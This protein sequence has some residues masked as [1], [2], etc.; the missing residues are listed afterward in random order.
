MGR[1]RPAEVAM[2]ARPA[3]RLARDHQARPRHGALL[4][5]SPRVNGKARPRRGLEAGAP[6]RIL[7][8]DDPAAEDST[9]AP[10]LRSGAA[11]RAGMSGG[12]TLVWGAGAIGG[13]VGAFLKRAGEDV[14][15]VDLVPEHVEAIRGPGGLR[16]TGPVEEFAV[17]APAL[18][19]EEAEGVCRTTPRRPAAPS[20]RTWTRT[21][22]CSRSRTACA[23]RPS[24]GSPG[25]RARW[26]PSSTSARTGWGRARSCSAIAAPWCWARS[27]AA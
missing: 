8:A 12:R 22:T 27:T 2:A 23:K 19:P 11:P 26:A 1:P 25:R 14:T 15:F 6:R 24:P 17:R 10:A 3:Q 16:I 21:G 7:R 18:L 13:T 4:R 20:C 5:P 9:H